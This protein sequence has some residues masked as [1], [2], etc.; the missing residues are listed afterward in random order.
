MP[1]NE[2]AYLFQTAL[3]WARTGY[4][5]SGQPTVTA[6]PKELAPWTRPR[7]S[8]VRWKWTKKETLDPKGNTITLDAVVTCQQDLLV[9]SHMWLGCLNDWNGTGSSFAHQDQ[10]LYVIIK[11]DRTP[12]IKARQV[13]R[14]ASLMRFHNKGAD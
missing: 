7:P 4:D 13:Y 8:G 1:Q 14:E 9:G 5:L 3:Y 11:F 2:V 10:Q 12:D 6:L